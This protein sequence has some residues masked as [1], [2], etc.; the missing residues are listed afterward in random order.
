MR[1]TVLAALA[2]LGVVGL[3]QQFRKLVALEIRHRFPRH[4]ETQAGRLPLPQAFMAAAAAAAQRLLV[5][6]EHRQ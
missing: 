2:A 4:K 6:Q 1:L 3:L 5:G